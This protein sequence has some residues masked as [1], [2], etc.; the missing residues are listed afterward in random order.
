[1]IG[2]IKKYKRQIK[3]MIFGTLTTV[4]DFTISFLL[5][6]VANHHIANT[7]AWFGAVVFAYAT[8]KIFV[9][10]SKRRGIKAIAAE[11]C[12]FAGSRLLS[13]FMQEGIFTLA[14]DIFDLNKVATKIA[15]SV[16]VVITNYFFCK[17]IFTKKEKA[18]NV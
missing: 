18:D 11:F 2:I 9:F 15:A 3:Y 1:M 6:K 8:N 12:V 7:V 14:V 10:E 5:Y 17:L 4:V 13:F 16:I